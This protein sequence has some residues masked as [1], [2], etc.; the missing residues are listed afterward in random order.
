MTEAAQDL[1]SQAAKLPPSERLQVVESILA[2]L[3]VPDPKIS[4]AWAHEAQDRLA[5]YQRG[6]IEA[7]DE[8]QVFGN[9]PPEK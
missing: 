9:L 6:E 7:V 4:A 1:V 8:E 2:T 3:D 5:A